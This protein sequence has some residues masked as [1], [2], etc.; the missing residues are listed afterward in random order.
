[1]QFADNGLHA[2]ARMPTQADRIDAAVVEITAILARLP[3]R[4]RR[5]DFDDPS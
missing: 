5:L 3:D 2:A 1:L 4:G